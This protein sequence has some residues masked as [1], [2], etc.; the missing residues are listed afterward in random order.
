MRALALLTLLTLCYAMTAHA[1][2]LLAFAHT[3]ATP[4]WPPSGVA[5]AALLVMGYRAWPAIF[6]GALLANLSTFHANG[7]ALHATTIVASLCIAFG[8]VLEA[9]TGAWMVRRFFDV[10]AAGPTRST[11]ALAG[12]PICLCWLLPGLPTATACAAPAW[13]A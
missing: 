13:C 11:T 5:F 1:S 6:V 2:L 7:V 8:N 10:K 12:C 4:V 3:N 9:L